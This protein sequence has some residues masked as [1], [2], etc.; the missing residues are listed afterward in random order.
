MKIITQADI[1]K[2]NQLYLELKTYAAVSRATG[3]SPGTVKKYVNPNYENI[4]KNNVIRYTRDALPEFEP[5]RFRAK[6]W[7]EMCVLSQEE[8][9]EIYTLWK[10]V[11]L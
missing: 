5:E 7:G 9:Q 8:V 4:S 10:E 6:D 11:E 2:I 1:K 3:F